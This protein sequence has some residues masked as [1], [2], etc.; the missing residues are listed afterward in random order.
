MTNEPLFVPFI[1]FTEVYLVT[2]VFDWLTFEE[3][4]YIIIILVKLKKPIDVG[5]DHSLRHIT[6]ASG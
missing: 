4:C 6:N 1:P 2:L 3:I 5:T